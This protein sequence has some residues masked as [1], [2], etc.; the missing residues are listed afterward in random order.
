MQRTGIASRAAHWSAK[1]RKAAILGWIAFVI[2]AMAV[3]NLT[4]TKF[5]A[6]E[7][8]G[9][10]DSRTGEQIIAGAG[11]PEDASEKVLIQAEERPVSVRPGVHRRRA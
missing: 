1:H 6:D 3:G 4:G 2:A 5:L 7:D 9:N 10:G 11:F 8:M